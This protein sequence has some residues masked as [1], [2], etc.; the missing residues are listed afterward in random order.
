MTE[1]QLIKTINTLLIFG[2]FCLGYGVLE[3]VNKPHAAEL[4]ARAGREIIEAPEE[5]P[6]GKA[7]HPVLTAEAELRNE[8]Q[9]IEVNY[10]TLK[11]DYIGRYFI[12]SYC[13]EECG[14][15]GSNYPTGWMTSSG[16]ICH[17]SESWSE[18]TTCAID[19][20]YGRRYG[21]LIQVGDAGD[22][23]KKIY[24]AEDTGPGVRGAWIDCFVLSMSEV[25]SWPTGWRNCYAVSYEEH[26]LEVNERKERHERLNSY[27]HSRGGSYWFYFGFGR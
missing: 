9:S 18:P 6:E 19:L 25:K 7:A 22:A 21:D 8:W 14:Y 12:T 2:G 15:N 23:D 26:T 5:I 13:P 11:L 20:S 16:A 1:K 3:F 17:Y 24:V 10:T 4:K 27:L